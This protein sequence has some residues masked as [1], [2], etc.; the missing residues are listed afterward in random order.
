MCVFMDIFH[1]CHSVKKQINFLTTALIFPFLVPSLSQRSPLLLLPTRSCSP[2]DWWSKHRKRAGSVPR[3]QSWGWAFLPS[4][5]TEVKSL[6]WFSFHLSSANHNART[7]APELWPP[8][9]IP[10]KKWSDASFTTTTPPVSPR[11]LSPPTPPPYYSFS[12]LSAGRFHVLTEPRWKKIPQVSR[13]EEERRK[14]SP[15]EGLWILTAELYSKSTITCSFILPR[16]PSATSNTKQ[17]TVF[18][19][20]KRTTYSS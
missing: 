2:L 3:R 16:I 18:W 20:T 6:P 15:A 13:H 12:F 10:V 8:W 11:F 14:T 5:C 17:T 7:A 19:K 1:R 9:K 4:S